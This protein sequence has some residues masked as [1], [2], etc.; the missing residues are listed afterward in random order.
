MTRNRLRH[1]LVT[2]LLA[3]NGALAHNA[4]TAFLYWDSDSNQGRLDVAIVDLQQ[5]TVLDSNADQQILW[6]EI[7]D[8]ADALERSLQSAIQVSRSEQYCA[9]E[10]Q[11]QGLTTHLDEHYA[12]FSL[13]P[14][15]VAEQLHYQLLITEDALHKALVS[16]VGG[17]NQRLTVLSAE[18]PRLDL[19]VD[20]DSRL[21]RASNFLWQGMLHLWFGYDHMLFLLTLMLA[22]IGFGGQR[23]RAPLV[24]LMR[25][26]LWIVT[27]FTVGHSLTLMV[28]ALGWWQPPLRLVEAMIA[29]SVSIAALNVLYPFMGRHTYRLALTFG[30]IHGFGF[31]SVLG[32]LLGDSRIP[33]LELI[34][35]NVGLELAQLCVVLVLLPLLWRAA[36]RP[37]WQLWMV[38]L[39]CTGILVTGL[40]WTIERAL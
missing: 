23:A 35:F 33:L 10:V 3:C 11:L 39:A 4:S 30:L 17:D 37:A 32:D 26:L 38:P 27:A 9:L 8:A 20:A 28:A 29:L 25:D 1:L 5:L 31:A 7:S 36:A 16:I 24:T 34:S 12:A 40:L 2:L 18:Q 14:D 21:T 6:H 15:C 22:A 13:Q 19:S